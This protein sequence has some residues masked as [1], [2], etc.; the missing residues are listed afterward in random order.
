MMLLLW[1]M[2]Q[3]WT[4]SAEPAG[5]GDMELSDDKLQAIIDL[6]D[7]LRAAMSDG[8]GEAEMDMGQEDDLDAEGGDAEM[9]MDAE[10]AHGGRRA[11]TM[12]TRK[13]L[14]LLRMTWW[15]GC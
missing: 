9:E 6:A 8:G 5:E 7:K 2:S 12:T 14:S 1:M 3:Q 11:R 15:R 13:T 10:E 4:W